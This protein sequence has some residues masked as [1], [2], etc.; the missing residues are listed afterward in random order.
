MTN[1]KFIK[2]IASAAKSYY[3]K[4]KI[5]P[6]L[7]IAQAIL[8][9]GWG[10]SKLATE[11][12]NYFGMKWTSDCGCKYKTYETSEQRSDGTYYKIYAKFRKYASL[13]KG[14]K[15]YYDF[16]N[17]PRY[18]NLV[19]VTDYKKACRLIR[20]DGW[21][22]SLSYTQSLISIIEYNK[23]YEYDKEVLKT[24]KSDS[25]QAK[26]KKETTKASSKKNFK[27]GDKV[28]V[29]GKIYCNGDGSGGYLRYKNREMVVVNL[30]DSGIY[31]HYIGVA[32]T[33]TGARLGWGNTKT[34]K[35]KK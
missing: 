2:K 25:K 4:Y 1:A 10:K 7:T 26:S 6:S 9:S 3:S 23:L 33:K 17:Y 13:K 31:E 29:N 22:T 34:I 20:E 19:G 5:L 18:K 21:A 32:M 16:I 8:E 11:C 24:D 12:H 27:I 35:S 28:I 15:G 14:I 30:V